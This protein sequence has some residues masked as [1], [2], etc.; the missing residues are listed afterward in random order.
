MPADHELSAIVFYCGGNDL[1]WGVSVDDVLRDVQRFV[2]IAKQR[3]PHTPVYL[4]SVGKTPSRRLSWKRVDALNA[5]LKELAHEPDVRF[6]DVSTAMLSPRGRPRRSL[7]L[8]DGIHPSPRGYAAWTSVLRPRLE[9]DLH[10][11]RPE[12]A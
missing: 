9:A 4:L 6:V 5:R 10:R 8:F 3:A 1:A 2:T 7:Y 12:S 11:G